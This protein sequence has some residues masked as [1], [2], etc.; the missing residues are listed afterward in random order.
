MSRVALMDE[1]EVMQA[2]RAAMSEAAAWKRT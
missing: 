1:V 2:V